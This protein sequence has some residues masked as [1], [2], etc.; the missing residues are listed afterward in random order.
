[1]PSFGIDEMPI[2]GTPF[3][4][5]KRKASVRLL[6]QRLLVIETDYCA[7]ELH[8][9]RLLGLALGLRGAEFVG[10]G[11]KLSQ[12]ANE[13]GLLGNGSVLV[14]HAQR[15]RSVFGPFASHGEHNRTDLRADALDLLEDRLFSLAVGRHAVD[16][17]GEVIGR[18]ALAEI[19]LRSVFGDV[20][21]V[22]GDQ[23]RQGIRNALGLGNR[24]VFVLDLRHVFGRDL[25]ESFTALDV[26]LQV[27][28]GQN[29]LLEADGALCR[30]RSL[31]DMTLTRGKR[32]IA[33]GIGLKNGRGEGCYEFEV[34]SAHD[35]CFVS[36]LLVVC[37]GMFM[38]FTLNH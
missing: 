10:L 25:G 15:A 13:V 20:E 26:V 35:V 12:R 3:N 4:L 2:L 30:L 17:G 37:F 8:L 18:I 23:V 29:R 7:Y 6:P 22:L 19:G 33:F 27:R 38:V 21:Q 16:E 36:N 28:D 5:D 32:G 14:G 31:T 9:R 1:M 11:E 34:L 24:S